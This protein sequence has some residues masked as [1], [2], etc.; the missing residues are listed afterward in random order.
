MSKT[1]KDAKAELDSIDVATG[2]EGEPY[3][4][5]TN[6]EAGNAAQIQLDNSTAPVIMLALAEA[7]RVP[8][9]GDFTRAR[10]GTPGHLSFIAKHLEQ[11]VV[12][13]EHITAEARERAELEA[14]ALKLANAAVIE[15]GNPP[16]PSVER[17]GEK[18]LRRWLA[19]ARRARE[20]AKE[21]TK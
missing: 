4:C 11:Y 19:V 12:E 10:A 13:N 17:M 1:F 9:Q 15:C 3:F 5:I 2:Y 7:A 8:M 6:I 14:E 16:Y 20:L 21:A 18:V